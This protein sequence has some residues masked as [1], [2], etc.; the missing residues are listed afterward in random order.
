MAWLE[1]RGNIYRINLDLHGQHISRSLRTSDA[2]EA[3]ACLKRVEANLHEIVRGRRQMPPGADVLV[4]LL[5]DGS[6]TTAPEIQMALTL[7]AF[8][9]RYK[10]G[11]PEGAKEANTRYI[12]SIHIEHLLRL[13]GAQTALATITAETLQ[14]YVEAR[15][16]EEGRQGK[17]ISHETVK[18]EIATLASAWN[19]YA[20]PQGLA[21]GSAPTKGLVY[22]KCKARPPFQTWEQ[23]ERQIG[24]SGLTTLEAKELW[25]SLFLKLPEVEALLDHVRTHAH[26]RYI[27]IMFSIAAC[28][29]ARRSEILRSRV[30]DF[31]FTAE[32]VTI[33]EKKRD[34]SRRN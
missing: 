20:V 28:T 5:S 34:R 17:P 23:I 26:A 30:E 24:R 31:D 27:F 16:K 21:Q 25:N 11:L 18:K 22:R 9:K 6:Q 1:K 29:G 8:F 12:E 33:R 2:E 7:A 13:I 4:F 10:T 19:R 3:D 32:C 14:K 15:S